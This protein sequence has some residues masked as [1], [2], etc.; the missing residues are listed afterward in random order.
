[1]ATIL[2]V[3]VGGP[4]RASSRL[5][6]HAWKP[7]L[8]AL[9]HQVAVVALHPDPGDG[10]AVSPM[11]AVLRSRV[12]RLAA[13]MTERRFWTGIVAAAQ[14]ADA[15]F[16][17]ET[18]P[19]RWATD[20]LGKATGRI[21]FDF[22]DPIHTAT[23]PG[24]NARHRLMQRM[25]T[26]PRLVHMLGAADAVVLEN[27]RI[28]PF[29][30]Q[31]GARVEVMRGPIDT[32]FYTPERDDRLAGGDLQGRASASAGDGGD[33]L[34]I[35]GWTGSNVTLRFLEPLVPMLQRIHRERPFRL[36]TVG[37]T[38]AP[39]FDG[40]D[41]V[42]TPWEMEAEARAVAGFDVALAW[43]PDTPWTRLRGGAKLLVYMA[44][45][46][47]VVASPGGIGDQVV[48]HGREGFLA[49][50]DAEWATRLT[51][52]LEDPAMRSRM[53]RDARE[54]AVEQHSYQAYLPLLCELL[55][56]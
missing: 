50:T 22:S 12:P 55:G 48:S 11:E 32:D 33:R 5:R 17:Q 14:M 9:G 41:V 51:T 10:P 20:A 49:A 28:R 38:E 40:L 44:A 27:D 54:T 21:V 30:E 34:P 23:G 26:N 8:Q 45:G 53:A 7:R 52:L 31:G 18:V 16:L 3:S 37:L 24:H 56:L 2:M 19:P 36:H 46:V 4:R 47:P 13:G 1:M 29:A 42:N 25:I 15:V 35:V 39:E 43:L 6:V